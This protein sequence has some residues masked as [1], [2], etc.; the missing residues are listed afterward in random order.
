[1]KENKKRIIFWFIVW[2]VFTSLSIY[3]VYLYRNGHGK[4]GNII[5]ILEPIS[6]EFNTIPDIASMQDIT[7][8]V[9][10]DKIVVTYQGA[11][12]QKTNYEFQYVNN[13]NIEYITNT[14]KDGTS[15]WKFIVLNMINAVYHYNGGIGS[16]FDDYDLETFTKTS[17]EEG[18]VYSEENHQL[19]LNIRVNLLDS[20][21]EKYTS[22]K[23]DI[24]V[25]E[26]DLV[27]VIDIIEEEGSFQYQLSDINLYI[28]KLD[29][30][31]EIFVSV[32]EIN[33]DRAMKSVANV[34]KVL[35]PNVYKTIVDE[36]GIITFE[37]ETKDY[38]S[39]ENATFSEADIFKPNDVIFEVVLKK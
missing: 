31:Y 20:L 2:L 21:K 1:M 3:G 35:K 37:A 33:Y 24:F 10:D 39:I 17:I 30:Q 14:D 8:K 4:Y 19:S 36:A 29:T 16:I 18:I 12:G 15:T 38:Y 5:K 28:R 11:G 27:N 6:V 7:S 13:N 22:K 26:E 9:K 23:E 34:I 32:T 25:K